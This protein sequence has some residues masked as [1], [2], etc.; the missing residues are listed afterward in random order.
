[1]N[2]TSLMVIL[3]A[4]ALAGGCGSDDSTGIPAPTAPRTGLVAEY[5][6]SGDAKDTSGY[7]NDGTFVN[8]AALATDR[9]GTPNAACLLDGVDDEVA[10]ADD[11]FAAG[12]FV[13]ASAWFKVGPLTNPVG[14]FA[15]CSDFGLW[16]TAT[17]AG[18]AISVP[19]TRSAYGALTGDGW[20]HLLGTYNGTNIRCYLDGVLVQTMSHPGNISDPDRPLLFGEWGAHW[21][22]WLDDVRIYDRVI[23]DPAEISALYH[24]GGYAQ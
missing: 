6:F 16:A 14:F 5:L 21:N 10:T 20:H 19:L 9:F 13:S 4:V 23:S 12:N 22:G 18:I 2:R 11:H 8:G 24:E 7:D 15:M 3:T 17:E 1:M